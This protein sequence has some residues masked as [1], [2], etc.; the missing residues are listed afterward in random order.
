MLLGQNHHFILFFRLLLIRPTYTVDVKTNMYQSLC[1]VC[2]MFDRLQPKFIY[3]EVLQ[4][5]SVIKVPSVILHLLPYGRTTGDVI[6]AVPGQKSAPNV[7]LL[8]ILYDIL[9]R[10]L[11]QDVEKHGAKEWMYVLFP[12]RQQ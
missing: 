7:K 11:T 3:Y 9:D 12:L 1:K 2:V 10:I 5:L 4:V 8:V 6:G